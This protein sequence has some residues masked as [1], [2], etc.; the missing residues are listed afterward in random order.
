[1]AQRSEANRQV[2]YGEEPSKRCPKCIHVDRA[3][4]GVLKCR[5]RKEMRVMS[6]QVCDLFR[7]VKHEFK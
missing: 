6:Y 2:K 5:K 7:K 3:E 1:M 4:M